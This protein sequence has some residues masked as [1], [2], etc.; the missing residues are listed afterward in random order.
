MYQISKA[1]QETV[2]HWDAEDKT[3]YIDTA[4]PVTIRKLDTLV[5]THPDTYRCIRTDELY[6]AKRYE[7]DSKYIRFGKPTSEARREI[8]RAN[9][10]EMQS[11]AKNY[12]H[13]YG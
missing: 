3:A 11:K 4:N 7:V 10:R 6:R 12:G 8:G 1:E 13:S 5:A 9:M 2:I